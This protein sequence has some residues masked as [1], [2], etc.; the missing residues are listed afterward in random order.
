MSDSKYF[1]KS[2]A[3]ELRAELDQARKKLKPHARIKVVLKK[4]IANIILNK[5]ELALLMLDIVEVM[6]IDDY[7]IRRLCSQYVVHFAPLNVKPSLFA[8]NFYSRFAEDLNPA[9]RA[10]AVKT[11]TSVNVKEFVKLGFTIAKKLI[12]DKNPHVRTNAAFSVARLFQYDNEKTVAVGLIDDLNQLLYDENQ[13][14]VANALAVLSSIT[15]TSPSLNLAIDKSHSLALAKSLSQANEWRQVYLLNALMS[16]VPL[17]PQNS[18]IL[19]DTVLPCL[20]HENSAVVLNAIKVIVYLSNYIASPE[21]LF[22]SLPK[23]LGSSLVSLLHKP[24]EVQFLVLRNVILILLG[25]RYLLDV[26]V[27]QF[28]WKFDDPIYVKD[29]KLEIIYLLADENNV[30]IVF[31]ELEEYA[32]E[33]D[34][35]MARKAIRAFGN[36]AV[37][38]EV[39]ASQCVEI[40]ADLISNE[41]PYIVQETAVVFKNIFRKY[42]GQFDYIIP[43]I[44]QHYELMDEPDAKVS[45]CWIIGQYSEELPIARRALNHFVL[46]FN[47]VPLEVQYAILTAVVK[48]YVNSPVEGEPLLLNVL[49]F[50]TEQSDN[51][52]LRDRG[53]FYWRLITNEANG[54]TDGDFQRKTKEVVINPQPLVT[55]ENDTIDPAILEELELNIGT[56]ASIYLKSVHHVFRLSKRKQLPASGTLQPRRKNT[57]TSNTNKATNQPLETP[58]SFKHKPL[59]AINRSGSSASAYLSNILS[60]TLQEFDAESKKESLGQKIS[61]KASILTRKNSKY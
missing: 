54:G 13:T 32:T 55:S 44:V 40:L 38:L 6:A 16:F 56:L 60:P 42:P 41:I 58:R 27:E 10:L 5:S 33:V 59:P 1:A 30:G 2:K 36:L 17:I 34:V 52:D 23:R 21:E 50:A 12:S 24:Y 9:L 26:E 20:Q 15:D 45:I 14:V 8:L 46:T 47:E 19:I 29:T 37:K 53:Y 4:V 18:L 7:E 35:H 31:N 39:A 61:R 22:P 25:K 3:S 43:S 28:F 11:V 51:P 48:Y 57:I 49:K